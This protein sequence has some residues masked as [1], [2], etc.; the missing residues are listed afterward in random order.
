MIKKYY[1]SPQ[2]VIQKLFLYKGAHNDV[3]MP[4]RDRLAHKTK[5][6]AK[7]FVHFAWH[8]WIT[9][10][11]FTNHVTYFKAR[12]CLKLSLGE[13]DIQC[14]IPPLDPPF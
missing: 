2:G 11:M 5:Q 13:I 7:Y 14:S 1:P 4:T 10:A 3:T 8:I 9:K 6:G 12:K